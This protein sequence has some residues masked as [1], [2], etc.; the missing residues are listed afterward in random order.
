M[1]REYTFPPEQ[2]GDLEAHFE[3]ILIPLGY[4]GLFNREELYFVI[5]NPNNLTIASNLRSA[6][7]IEI[8]EKELMEKGFMLKRLIA[9]PIVS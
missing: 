8:A 3:R 5:N 6:E 9:N 4:S 7:E 2:K 1:E